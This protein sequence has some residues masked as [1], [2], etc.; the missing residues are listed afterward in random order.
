VYVM[1]VIHLIYYDQQIFF[2]AFPTSSVEFVT[3]T[4]SSRGCVPRAT[5]DY[6]MELPNVTGVISTASA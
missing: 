1:L 3:Y 6:I 5:L 2:Y 4:I